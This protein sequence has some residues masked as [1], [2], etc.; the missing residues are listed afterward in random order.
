MNENR[1]FMLSATDKKLVGWPIRFNESAMIKDFFEVIDSHALDGVNMAGIPL[2]YNH[3]FDSLPLAR[4]PQTMKLTVKPEGLY[5]EAS[6][7]ESNISVYEAVKRGDITGM[8]FG[9]RVAGESFDP[10]TNT[11]TIMK[12]SEIL[13]ISLAPNPAYES[14]TVETR[15]KMQ[16][17]KTMNT[18]TEIEKRAT[19]LESEINNG[20]NDPQLRTELAALKDKIKDAETRARTFREDFSYMTGDR[21]EMNDVTYRNAFYKSLLGQALTEAETT[22]INTARETRSDAF[23]TASNSAAVL[24]THTLDEIIRK[25]RDQRG[26]IPAMRSFNIPAKVSV[27]V[28][29]PSTRAAWHVEGANVETENATLAPVIF[30][31]FELVKIFSMSAKVRKTSIDNFEAYL[32]DELRETV[33]EAIEDTAI[34]GTGTN[35]PL[36]LLAG[37]TW[38]NANSLTSDELTYS[39]ILGAVS[40]LKGGYTAGASWLMSTATL[41]SHIYTMLDGIQRPIFNPENG[42]RILGYSVILSDYV[43]DNTVIFGNFSYLAYNMPE[44]VLIE[45]STD[46]AFRKNLIDIRATAIADIKVLVPEAFVKLTVAQG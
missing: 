13:E 10:R 6:I 21:K 15:N 38:T 18:L 17:A 5:M 2:I 40:T 20:K 1:N 19:E 9:F 46:S 30:D 12:I 4:T 43:P 8:S 24:P 7:S 28:S 36:G 11:R 16:E 45:T 3:N 26:L 33:F 25:A 31:N 27:P 41:Y 39:D 37:V 42:G 14:A 22:S 35:E 32:A 44:G 34:N 23:N 29:T